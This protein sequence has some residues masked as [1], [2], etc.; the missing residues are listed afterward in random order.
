V[1]A[2]K[3]VSKEGF[4]KIYRKI[5]DFLESRNWKKVYHLSSLDEDEDLKRIIKLFEEN[6]AIKGSVGNVSIYIIPVYSFSSDYSSSREEVRVLLA[7]LVIERDS[8]GYVVKIDFLKYYSYVNDRKE[9][10]K[11]IESNYGRFVKLLEGALAT[12]HPNVTRIAE[13]SGC[14]IGVRVAGFLYEIYGDEILNDS[15]TISG[16]HSVCYDKTK[17]FINDKVVVIPSIGLWVVRD[18]RG[19]K[20]FVY[21]HDIEDFQE[22]PPETKVFY[23]VLSKRFRDLLK[24]EVAVEDVSGFKYA[25]SSSEAVV[26]G[27]EVSL[28]MINEY[29]PYINEWYIHDILAITCG[30]WC[31]IYSFKAKDYRSSFFLVDALPGEL[32]DYLP[33]Y[34]LSSGKLQ[35]RAKEMAIEEFTKKYEW[36]ILP[37]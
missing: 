20:V 10:E 30:N 1:Y 16:L 37:A 24:P 23:D 17:F 36:E 19:N 27:K 29:D 4:D 26:D 7:V 9:A 3:E 35:K 22:V 6:S 12:K 32:V 5:R 25:F 8:S 31:S 2:F 15:E 34:I 11:F 18:A 21:R 28:V 13:L 33:G 14:G